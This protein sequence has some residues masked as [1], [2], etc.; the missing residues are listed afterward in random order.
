MRPI[1]IILI[2]IF[3]GTFLCSLL[4]Q[5]WVHLRKQDKGPDREEI[6]IDLFLSLYISLGATFVANTLLYDWDIL[7]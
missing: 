5:V 4:T 7:K 3:V 2:G 1:N 6:K